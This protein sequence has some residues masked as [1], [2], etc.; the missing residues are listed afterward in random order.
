[1]VEPFRDDRDDGRRKCFKTGLLASEGVEDEDDSGMAM[2][3]DAQT[4]SMRY[5]NRESSI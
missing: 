3:F 2:R 1:M 5:G 4:A